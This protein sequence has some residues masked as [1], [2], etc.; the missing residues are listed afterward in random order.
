MSQTTIGACLCGA[1][2]FQISGAFERFFLCHCT[3]CRKGTGSAH[4]ANL[5]SSTAVLTW[6]SGRDSIKAY[7]VP[8]THHEKSFCT[9]CG[10]ALPCIQGA[11]LVVPAGSLECAIDIRPNAH[12]CFASRAQWD[13]HL[14]DIPK[15]DGLPR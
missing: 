3:R 4:A 8:G 6:L 12:I 7:R 5:F 15:I 14:E 1:V 13:T 9:Q 2:S 10:S 11:L